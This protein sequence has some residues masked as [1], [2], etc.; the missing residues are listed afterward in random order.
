MLLLGNYY[1]MIFLITQRRDD[2][3]LETVNSLSIIFMVITL[4]ISFFLPIGL[5][6]WVKVKY[7]SDLIAFFVGVLSFTVSQLCIRIPILS[8]MQTQD[9]YLNFSKSHLFLNLFILS[10]TAGLF[11]ETARL[12]CFKT[13]LKSKL[14]HKNAFIFGV[15]HGG[16]EAIVLIG[17]TYINNL[18]LSILINTGAL[19]SIP[20]IASLPAETL[21]YA[22]DA[23]TKTAP[24]SFLFAGTER[25]SAIFLHIALSVI[26]YRGVKYNKKFNYLIALSLHGLVNVLAVSSGLTTKLIKTAPAILNTFLPQI[27]LFA[28]LVGSII[29]IRISRKDEVN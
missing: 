1:D 26:V 27:V 15:G 20:A 8:M 11:E 6:I 17:L 29:Y 9:W 3:Q 24:I 22:V 2:M 4:L 21:D 18:V 25:I 14:S 7:K 10:M 5:A 19:A 23:L 12:I 13:L 16:I 28:T